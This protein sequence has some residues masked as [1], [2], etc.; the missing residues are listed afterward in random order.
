[1]TLL[2]PPQAGNAIQ[3]L[4]DKL[5]AR[6]HDLEVIAS[7]Y[8][9]IVCQLRSQQQCMN[10]LAGTLRQEHAQ[11][12]YAQ[13][14]EELLSQ[15]ARQMHFRLERVQLQRNATAADLAFHQR[16][17]MMVSGWQRAGPVSCTCLWSCHDAVPR[18]SAMLHLVMCCC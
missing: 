1:M 17:Q 13:A 14:T 11:R 2:H 6:D 9:S 10:A 3:E 15:K 4:Q 7:E 18:K 5:A 8:H 12:M 16:C